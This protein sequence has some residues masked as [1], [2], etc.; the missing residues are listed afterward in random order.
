M[1]N[2]K[3]FKQIQ[4]EAIEYLVAN[5]AITQVQAGGAA[6]SLVDIFSSHLADFYTKL[7]LDLSMAYLSTASG[8]YLDLIGR[9]FGVTRS[10]SRPVS[11][12]SEDKA[13]KLYVADGDRLSTYLPALQVPSGTIISTADGAVSYK[14]SE[15][16]SFMLMDQH[17]FVSATAVSGA[18]YETAG[19][20]TINTHNLGVSGIMATN[21]ITLTSGN[22]IE[23]DSSFRTRI[24]ANATARQGANAT[25]VQLAALGVPNVADVS[26]SEFARGS[27]SF[28]VMVIPAGNRVPGQSMEIIKSR[29]ASVAAFG[30][31][32]DVREPDYVQVKLEMRVTF[33]NSIN[34]GQ[35]AVFLRDIETSVLGYIG[36]LRPG[37]EMSMS[38]IQSLALS[39][40]SDVQD[41]VITFLCIDKKAHIIRNIKLE[42]DEVFIPDEDFANPIVI[43]I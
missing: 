16:A 14:T 38:R 1:I 34:T 29:L 12:L 25:A 20:G 41:A 39:L 26:I 21:L 35:Q 28:E 7:D 31:S 32:F 22:V 2:K 9:L 11:L 15:A 19:I 5:T 6:R 10:A 23:G 30:V 33:K 3:S 40:S 27:G 24:S 18:I 8:F 42:D 17:V 4:R 13:L 37:E 36:D 43:R